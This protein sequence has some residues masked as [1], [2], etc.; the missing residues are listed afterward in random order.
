[1]TSSEKRLN[2]E[3]GKPFKQ[4]DVRSDGKIFRAYDHRVTSKGVVIYHEKWE[5][6]VAFFQRRTR[7]KIY[8]R[9]YRKTPAGRIKS[10]LGN[11]LSSAKNR[12]I[13]FNITE[14]DILPAIEKG[15]CELTGLPFDLSRPKGKG[16]NPYAPSVDRISSDKGYTKNNVRVVL[17]AVNAALSESSDEEMLPIL[18]AMVKA[19][20]KNVKQEPTTPV[21]AGSDQQGKINS[22]L[23]AIPTTGAGQDDNNPDHHSG[24][25][26][27]QDVDHSTQ[28]GGGDSV[29]YRSIEM[30]PFVPVTRLEDHGQPDA[31][32]V[33]LEFGSRHLPD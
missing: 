11:C 20:E 30:E 19:I 28:E 4:G 9:E 31:E 17:W 5:D 2:P 21:S 12:N 18:K 7:R 1:M 15:H 13:Y 10:I 24:T 27:G 14:E 6:E 32:I 3:T 23:G 26:R 25:V 8:N 29:A 16:K 33:R 22:K